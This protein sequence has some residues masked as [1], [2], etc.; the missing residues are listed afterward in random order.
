M[1]SFSWG[2]ISLSLRFHK[3]WNSF[4]RAM[5]IDIAPEGFHRVIEGADIREGMVQISEINQLGHH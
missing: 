3:E 1:G 5:G 4:G 2:T